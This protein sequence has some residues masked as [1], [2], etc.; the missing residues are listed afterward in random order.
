[1]SDKLKMAANGN[2]IIISLELLYPCLQHNLGVVAWIKA[3]DGGTLKYTFRR[4]SRERHQDRDRRWLPIK[5]VICEAYAPSNYEDF[6]AL[7]GKS[8]KFPVFHLELHL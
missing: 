3:P 8:M 2:E 1:M 6:Y 7:L 5:F 4:S